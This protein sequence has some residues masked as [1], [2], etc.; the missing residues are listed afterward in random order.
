MTDHPTSEALE[1]H[2]A[3]REWICKLAPERFH[4]D[5]KA[6]GEC[7]LCVIAVGAMAYNEPTAPVRGANTH[8]AYSAQEWYE[9]R[10]EWYD[11]PPLPS[12]L[13]AGQNG[14]EPHGSNTADARSE[15]D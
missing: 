15:R 4:L 14:A 10:R 3:H 13:R 12:R 1:V 7:R 2:S 11:L 8:K 6:H 9:R 5:Y